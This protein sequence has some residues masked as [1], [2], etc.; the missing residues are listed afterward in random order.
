MYLKGNG[1]T[2]FF[3]ARRTFTEPSWDVILSIQQIDL[4]HVFYEHT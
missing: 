4:S 1:K 3:G 2:K